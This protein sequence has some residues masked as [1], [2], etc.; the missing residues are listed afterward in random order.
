MQQIISP[1][2]ALLVVGGFAWGDVKGTFEVCGKKVDLTHAYALQYDNEERLIDGPEL[3][4]LLVDREIDPSLLSVAVPAQ[5]NLMAADGKLCGV[6]LRSVKSE[7]GYA[8]HGTVF[9]QPE[10]PRQS[11]IF[12]TKT[13]TNPVFKQLDV[14]DGKVSGEVDESS[15][16]DD[17]TPY[18]FSLTF[19]APMTKPDAVT[20]HFKGAEAAASAPAKAFLD[21]EKAC[22]TG[23]LD[24]ARKLST[25]AG[26]RQIDE[27]VKQMGKEAFVSQAAQFIPDPAKLQK[28]IVE[29]VVRGKR[30]V[31][32][33]EEDGSRNGADMIQDGDTWKSE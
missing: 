19:S 30:A 18:K 26:M 5:F 16:E 4:I 3:R 20:A 23:D 28:E 17:E 27:A 15:S 11:M 9:Y 21:F 25:E 6:F 8:M 10:D 14:K 32:I 2:L 1:I 7:D 22:R 24:A 31:V 33:I 12:F 29:V 13:G